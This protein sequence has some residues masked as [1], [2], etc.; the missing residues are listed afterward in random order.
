MVD[1][2]LIIG[3][4][5]YLQLERGMSQNTVE[6]YLHDVRLLVS[7]MATNKRQTKIT[8]IVY[9]DLI[10]FIEFVNDIDMG[11]HTQARIIS[12]IKAFFRY[13]L[14]EKEIE[15]NPSE[16][17][18]TPKLGR[19]LPDVLSV[20]DIE[21]ILNAV[22]LSLPEGERNKAIL[23]TLYGCGLRVSEL[24]NLSI[25][26]YHPDDMLMSVK[27]KGN[28]Q[29]LVPLGEHTVKQINIYLQYSRVKSLGNKKDNGVLFLNRRGN[30]LT[31]QMIFE[32]VKKVA[33][34]AGIRKSI[35][36]HSFRHA[37]ATHLVQNGADLRVV[38]ELL[39]HVS[40]M[41]TEIYTHINNEDLRKAVNKYHPRN[42]N[43][44]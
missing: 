13:L 15:S 34:C 39:G 5:S 43:Q 24:V 25:L 38:Q 37:F 10:D 36:P 18:E 2:S 20:E 31:R 35:S 11:V 28:K 26:D 40:I 8:D 14:I 4:K 22:N 42:K 1:N 19:K 44:T 21:L 23:E 27:G 3:F 12:G 6:A 16:L 30:K 41:T 9:E 7:F 17:I 29:R 33:E 32:I